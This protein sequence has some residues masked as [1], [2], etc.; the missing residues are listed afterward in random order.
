MEIVIKYTNGCSKHIRPSQY[1]DPHDYRTEGS[2]RHS[3]LQA[4]ITD[5]SFGEISSV[6][7]TDNTKGVVI[8]R[9]YKDPDKR[10]SYYKSPE[11]RK[12]AKE[13]ISSC[14]KE[15]TKLPIEN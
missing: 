1:F 14:S 9:K 8:D 13:V 12:F 2:R 10:Y 5:N 15:W 11:E 4:M 7:V 6:L 3:N